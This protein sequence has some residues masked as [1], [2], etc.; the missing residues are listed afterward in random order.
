MQAVLCTIRNASGGEGVNPP[1]TKSV[2]APLQESCFKSLNF[3]VISTF[4]MVIFAGNSRAASIFSTS[5]RSSCPS[6]DDRL[7][8]FTKFAGNESVIGWAE[9]IGGIPLYNIA[10]V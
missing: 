4:L 5:H 8:F 7:K 2:H 10:T 9:G 1:P 3:F 6:S